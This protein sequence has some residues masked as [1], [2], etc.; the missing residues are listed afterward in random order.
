MCMWAQGFAPS[1]AAFFLPISGLGQKVCNILDVSQVLALGTAPQYQPQS[2]DV[3][4]RARSA[5]V[6]LTVCVSLRWDLL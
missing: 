2:R 3:D 4:G 6:Y 5:A 1:F